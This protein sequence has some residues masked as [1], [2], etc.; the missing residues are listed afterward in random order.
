[1]KTIVKIFYLLFMMFPVMVMSCQKES[2][3]PVITELAIDG[4]QKVISVEKNGIGIEFCLLNEQGQPAT[5]FNEGEDFRFHLV[6][7]NNVKSCETLYIPFCR[8]CTGY[9]NS[10][11]PDEFYVMSAQGNTIGRPFY[12]RGADFSLERCFK[13][14]KGERLV[15]L[16]I[17][18]T[19]S[20]D[21]WHICNLYAHG[22]KNEPLSKGIYYVSFSHRFCFRDFTLP[23]LGK[24]DEFICSDNISLKIYFEIK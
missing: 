9:G 6:I 5:V 23:G 1:M 22:S 12:I 18:W 4:K 11:F 21:Y 19:E 7:R 3:E 15:M 14:K 16:D 17:P 20:R 13:I 10:Y 8:D 24:P 2:I